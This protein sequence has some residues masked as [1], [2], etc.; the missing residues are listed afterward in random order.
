LSQSADLVGQIVGHYRILELLASGGMAT[1]Y[2]AEDVHLHRRVALKVFRL[3]AGETSTFL[4]YF[5]REARVLANLD[6]P[7]IL[8]V[9]DYGEQEG[10]AY[11]VMPLMRQGSLKDRLLSHQS[12]SI[13]EVLRLAEQIL[14]TLQ[15]AHERGLVHRDIKP[16]N[17]LFKSDGTLLL[18]DFGL[19]KI[20]AAANEQAPAIPALVPNA[21]APDQSSL[22]FIGTPAYMAPEQI[23]GQALP[24]SDL[25]SVGVVLYELLTGRCPFSADTVVDILRQHLTHPPRPLRELNPDIPPQVET[26]V[27]HALEKDPRQRYQSASSFLQALRAASQAIDLQRAESIELEDG[28]QSPPA[29]SLRTSV[30]PLKTQR[31][32]DSQPAKKVRAST[33]RPAP[34]ASSKQRRWVTLK[35]VL[36]ALLILVVAGSSLG[37]LLY[38]NHKARSSPG[39]TASH[40]VVRTATPSPT[41]SGTSLPQGNAVPVPQTCPKDEAHANKAV[42][43][44]LPSQGNHQNLVYLASGSLPSIF[45]RYD[46]STHRSYMILKLLSWGYV[47]EAQISGDGHWILFLAN[48]STTTPPGGVT[49]IQM[50]RLDGQYLQTLYCSTKIIRSILWSPDA[51]T[52]VFNALSPTGTIN[53]HTLLTMYELETTTGTLSPLLK[54]TTG[55]GYTPL[56][57]GNKPN[58]SYSMF[59][60]TNYRFGYAGGI[61][62]NMLENLYSFVI[63]PYPNSPVT[64][65]LISKTNGC[66][67]YVLSPDNTRLFISRCNPASGP[68]GPSTI[69]VEDTSD[70]LHPSSPR[71]ILSSSTLAIFHIAAISNTT[72]LFDVLNQSGDTTQDGVWKINMDGTGLRRLTT[73]GLLDSSDDFLDSGAYQDPWTNISRDGQFYSVISVYGKGLSYGPLNGTESQLTPVPLPARQGGV[74]GWATL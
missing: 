1:V 8:L 46:I 19:V 32:A 31:M 72:L 3:E 34:L 35:L 29:P 55:T 60:A 74:I 14:D 12:Y 47:N 59:Y 15:Y 49:K 37:A 10:L 66:Q 5:S 51:R 6:H 7:H 53:P 17:L 11:L 9:H 21:T 13:A 2:Q 26:A 40:S 20:L 58:V 67:T 27:M 62:A 36:L 69:Q 41:A 54:A 38:Q 28:T 22:A 70:P 25:Y 73:R 48:Y 33:S 52:V 16:A 65:V 39:P 63:Y 61:E 50:V 18:A 44:S 71:T 4:R 45:Q 23:Q 57:W 64:P 56:I 42:M 30:D 24:Q 68:Q 43:P